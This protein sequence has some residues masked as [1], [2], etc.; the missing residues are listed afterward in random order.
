[1]M[2]ITATVLV[3]AILVFLGVFTCVFLFI[4]PLILSLMALGGKR[5]PT[6][7]GAAAPTTGTSPDSRSTDDTIIDYP[8]RRSIGAIRGH[9][10]SA[11]Y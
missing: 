11:A 9:S 10:P 8:K 3:A 5:E 2:D 1:M 7:V 6:T 4:Y